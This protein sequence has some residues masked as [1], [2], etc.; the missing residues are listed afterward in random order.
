MSI[1]DPRLA[2]ALD[3]MAADDIE[4]LL[5]DVRRDGLRVAR[6]RLVAMY[7][8]A[9][10]RAV[11]RRG[12]NTVPADVTGLGPPAPPG[13][14]ST[15]G[16]YLYAVVAGDGI[17][18]AGGERGIEPGGPV[19]VVVGDG[20]SAVVSD[21]DIDAMREGGER[22][23]LDEDSW[24]ANAVRAHERVVC[25][26][27]RSAPTIPM[28]FGVVHADGDT[29]VHLLEQYDAELRTEL[30][31]IEGAAEWS[32]RVFADTDRVAERL[33]E[34]CH[35]GGDV[36]GGR[37][38][39][40]RERARRDLDERVRSFLA[41]R[42][43]GL[44]VLLESAARE[45]VAT[46]PAAGEARRPCFSSVY[47]VDRADEGRLSS[48]VDDFAAHTNDIGLTVELDGPWPPYHFTTLRL[49]ARSD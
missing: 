23:D 3:V 16:C 47:L 44:A 40:L 46:P 25:A 26:A 39:L 43:D 41:A 29:V 1:D 30:H 34:S 8:E 5:E 20:I 6:T 19:H 37:A 15:T 21:V 14:L 36:G 4:G 49:E 22:G 17:G 31:R 18:A 35:D 13:T 24:L 28:R 9:L 32:V 45:V 10:L 2:G 48:L 42:V 7:A 27:F 38:F 33:A 12:G 11:P